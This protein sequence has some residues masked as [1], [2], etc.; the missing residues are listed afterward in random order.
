MS[1]EQQ[2]TKDTITRALA[3]STD[4]LLHRH[5]QSDTLFIETGSKILSCVELAMQH[6]L[7]AQDFSETNQGVV[8]NLSQGSDLEIVASFLLNS[9]VYPSMD[10]REEAVVEAYAKT[11]EWIF[12]TQYMETVPWSNF[13]EWLTVGHGIYWIKG[14]AA[15]GKTTLM[16]FITNDG[17][18]EHAL[19]QWSAGSTL[20]WTKFFFWNLGTQMQ[21]SQAGLLR[22]LLHQILSKCPDLIWEV[23]PDIWKLIKSRSNAE[24]RYLRLPESAWCLTKMKNAFKSILTQ[25]MLPLKIC[26]LI[27]GLDEYDGDHDEIV[28]FFHEVSLFENVKICVSSRPL[29]IFEEQLESCPR[30]RLQDL[31]VNDITIYVREKLSMHRRARALAEQD[32]GTLTT[33]IEEIVQKSSGV[34]LWVSLVV[35]SLLN[36]LTNYDNI[37]DLRKRLQALPNELDDLFERML[38]SIQPPFYVEQASRLFLITCLT[39]EPMTMLGLSLADEKDPKVAL[40]A[41][42]PMR[43]K[44]REVRIEEMSGRMKSRCAG[45]L[46]ARQADQIPKVARSLARGSAVELACFHVDLLHLTVKQFL[47]KPDIWERLLGSTAERRFDGHIALLQSVVAELRLYSGL[48]GGVDCC[49]QSQHYFGAQERQIIREKLELERYADTRVRY[50]ATYAK[51]AGKDTGMVQMFLLDQLSQLTLHRCEFKVS[52]PF[53][54][55]PTFILFVVSHGLTEYV[56]SKVAEGVVSFT[57]L[58]KG[59]I[60]PLLT[61]LTSQLQSPGHTA[62]LS[63]LLEAGLDP[64]ERRCGMTPWRDLL[65]RLENYRSNSV[66]DYSWTNVSHDNKVLHE[67]WLEIFKLFTL[68]GAN[69]NAYVNRKGLNDRFERRVSALEIMQAA[70]SHLPEHLLQE[71]KQLILQRKTRHVWLADNRARKRK[72]HRRLQ[73][74]LFSKPL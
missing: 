5:D 14:K 2:D 50:A 71:V 32:P 70:F 36:G 48:R 12:Q 18:T 47:T 4:T 40:G 7:G 27:D 57:Q 10:M 22:S 61:F 20:V 44:E 35:K 43:F 37:A 45:L 19:R 39:Q 33:F 42:E 26:L 9:L 46:E 49:S 11:F 23:V 58:S 62:T 8:K 68:H 24:L 63:V 16:K 56:R 72:N 54:L 29:M 30:L 31:T 6:A 60:N 69:L 55:H 3:A 59:L 28:T 34:F 13:M 51:Q 67:S 65:E 53:L 21:K 64:N 38:N 66:P 74:S 25:T 1:H 52:T 15:S 17:R 41:S 73:F